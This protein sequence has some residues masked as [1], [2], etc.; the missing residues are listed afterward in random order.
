MLLLVPI[1]WLLVITDLTLKVVGDDDTADIVTSH[2]LSVAS[3]L[4]T[5]TCSIILCKLEPFIPPTS[6]AEVRAF[7]HTD[8]FS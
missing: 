4:H 8:L 7:H 3:C 6:L 2:Y 5:A 1:T